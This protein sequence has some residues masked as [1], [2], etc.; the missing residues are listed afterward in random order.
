MY[1]INLIS[2]KYVALMFS[3]VSVLIVSYRSI[4]SINNKRYRILFFLVLLGQIISLSSSSLALLA[5]RVSSTFLSFQIPL[6]GCSIM[7]KD[8]S[9]GKFLFE[10]Y[11][12]MFLAFIL[13]FYN[14]FIH[15][16]L[17]EFQF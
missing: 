14:L 8:N 2:F 13:S 15:Q 16:R 4:F 12:F 6:I 5:Y 11:Y 7:K 17:I 3:T 10:K 1:E 9:S